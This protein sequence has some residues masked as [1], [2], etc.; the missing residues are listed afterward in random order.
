M[1]LILNHTSNGQEFIENVPFVVTDFD[2]DPNKD[3][4]SKNNVT[5]LSTGQ[6]TLLHDLMLYPNPT[7]DLLQLSVPQG[8]QIKEVVFYNTIGQKI[9]TSAGTSW[10]VADLASGVYFIK[11]FTNSGMKQIRFVKE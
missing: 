5:S 4:I 10:N 6:F 8:L 1:D 2:F 7:A 11:V 9:K 3:I